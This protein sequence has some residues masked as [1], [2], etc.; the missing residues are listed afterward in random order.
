MLPVVDSGRLV[1]VIS[2]RDFLREFSYGEMPGS[3]EP[4]ASLLTARP[5][6]AVSPDA[7]RTP[8]LSAWNIFS[9]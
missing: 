5:P 1:G 4:I 8:E 9:A 7:R 2:S 6:E 3:R